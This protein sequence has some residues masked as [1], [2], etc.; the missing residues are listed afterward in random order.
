MGFFDMVKSG[1]KF[2]GK[3]VKNF[4]DD[5]NK[6]KMEYS[7]YDDERLKREFAR[8][9]GAKKMAIASLL[10]ERGYGSN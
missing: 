8:A 3:Q 1:A 10:K 5:F 4:N 9:S 6:Y 2:V 7:S